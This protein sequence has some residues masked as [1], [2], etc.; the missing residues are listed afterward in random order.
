MNRILSVTITIKTENTSSFCHTMEKSLGELLMK[1]GERR[2]Y[3]MKSNIE[4][5]MLHFSTQFSFLFTKLVHNISFK[6]ECRCP[7]SRY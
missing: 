7:F 1:K 3:K 2:C 6:N 4:F 5:E